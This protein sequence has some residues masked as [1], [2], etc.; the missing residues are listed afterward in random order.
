MGKTTLAGEAAQWWTRTGLFPDGACF[1]S[2]EQFSNAERVIQVLGTYLEGNDFNALSAEK[3]R[4]RAREL[5]QQKR[6]LMVWDNFESVLPQFNEP[7]RSDGGVE[8]RGD[9]KGGDAAASNTLPLQQSNT[10][11]LYSASE[12]QRLYDLYTDWT[13]GEGNGRLLI[14]CRPGDEKDVPL[15]GVRRTELQGL[16]R[17]DS[18]WLLIRVLENSGVDVDEKQLTRERLNPLLDL[19]NDH[20]LSIELVRPHLKR[21]TPEQ[22]CADFGKLLAEFKV[23]AGKERNES[24]LASLAF[25][26]RRLSDAAQAALPWLGLFRG[27]VF[28]D[29]LLDVSEMDP[30]QW[31]AVRAELE[32]TALIRIGR[33]IGFGGDEKNPR[34]YLRFHPTLAYAAAQFRVPALADPP[35]HEQEVAGSKDAQPPKGGTPNELRKRFIGVYLA[36]MQALDKALR[37]S[38][39]REALEILAREEAN[40]RT[41]VSWAVADQ[42]Y[43]VA[44]FLGDTF[45]VYLERSGRLRERD[46]W[47]A[48]LAGEVGKA[49]F[50]AQ[51]AAL[52]QQQAWSLFTQGHPQEALD[53]LKALIER[54]RHTTEF[55]PAFQLANTQ[56]VLGRVLDHCGL[57]EQAIPELEEAVRQWEKLVEKEAGSRIVS[58]LLGGPLTLALSPDGGEG[59]RRAGEGKRARPTLSPK[60]IKDALQKAET[61]L[62]NL[63][64]TLGDL[65]NALSSAGRLDEALE[66]SDRGLQIGAQLGRELLVA[67]SNS[68]SAQILMQQGR[69]AEADAR[70]DAALAAARRAGDKELEGSLLQHQGSLAEEQN[71]LDRAASLYQRALKLFQEMNDNEGEMQ[72]CNLV[73]V[74]EQKAGRLAEART[75]YERSR[76]LAQRLGAKE[77]F[78]GVTRNLAIVCQE[79]AK[80]LIQAGEQAKAD[81]LLKT[82]VRYLDEGLAT[83]SEMKNEPRSAEA[84]NQ[85]AQVHFLLGELAEAERHAHQARETNERL[86][87]LRELAKNLWVLSD[88]ARAKKDAAQA[89]EWERKRDAVLEELERRARG[90]GGG[91]LPPQFAQA[92]QQ[93]SIACAQAGFGGPQPQ[94]LDPGAESALAQLEKLPVPMPDLAAFLRRLAARELPAVPS[95]LPPEL[96]QYLAQVVAAA[97]EASASTVGAERVQRGKDEVE[98]TVFAPPEVQPG[99]AVL[100]Q[101]FAHLAKEAQQASRLAKKADPDSTRRGGTNLAALVDRG[102]RLTFELE[103]PPLA[104]RNP[105]QTLLWAGKTD[106]LQFAVGV[107]SNLPAQSIVGTIYVSLDSMPLGQVSF[108]LVLVGQGQSPRRTPHQTGEAHRYQQAFISYSSKDRREVLKR[109]PVLAAMGIEYRQDI[110]SL[111]PGDEWLSKL[112]GWIEESDVFLLFWS[113]NAKESKWVEMEWRHALNLGR[114]GF[115]R[116]VSIEGPPLPAPPPELAHLHFGERSLYTNPNA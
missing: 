24:L 8:C 35:P 47:V 2:F 44:S 82:A 33:D 19:V 92:I 45:S 57:S 63:S 58:E 60:Q 90:P 31:E 36:V 80:T 54:L 10:P 87:L 13:A 15:P 111:E 55:D 106:S 78:A 103:M 37:G 104:V 61:A 23:G 25:S 65:A 48:W 95:T 68:R 89:A 81:R 26:T 116:P 7:K 96:Q 50:T 11:S 85:L 1:L 34:Y 83:H 59:A 107:P 12:R 51:A 16:A 105:V 62:N 5:F 46:A 72:T 112:R 114:Q 18:L 93:L 32:A 39:S 109:V 43:D 73:G 22:I 99:D 20:P 14:T 52:E 41:A 115:I 102:S 53:K 67:E 91:G 113:S 9:G 29:N 56:L 49:G 30:A 100:I 6:V 88:I 64:A 70:Y 84:H 3:Q 77:D 86:G 79:E 71:Q 66:A 94:D 98:C 69:F 40:Y 21:L 38:Q 108:K 17:P 75:W 97:K 74:V 28:E 76:E 101:V 42:A 4:Q 27:G 110:F